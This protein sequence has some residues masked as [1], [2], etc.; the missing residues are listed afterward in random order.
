MVLCRPGLNNTN[1]TMRV[2][3]KF[4]GP[5]HHPGS[6]ADNEIRI[7]QIVLTPNLKNDER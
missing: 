5:R 7:A 6:K 4:T 3:V 2:Y 1:C